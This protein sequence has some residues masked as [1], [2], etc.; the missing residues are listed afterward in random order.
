MT[1]FQVPITKRSWRVLEDYLR[2]TGYDYVTPDSW[3]KERMYLQVDSECKF[4]E[5]HAL[6]SSLPYVTDFNDVIDF[7]RPSHVD[8]KGIRFVKTDDGKVR[9]NVNTNYFSKKGLDLMI[10][11]T[12]LTYKDIPNLK[13]T[14][15]GVV[16]FG[17]DIE[18]NHTELLVIRDGLF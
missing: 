4:M 9:N 2:K 10:E 18:L 3:P 13:F 6:P 12:S 11:G 8:I 14:M 1:K 7:L 15:N 17:G 5:I 16:H